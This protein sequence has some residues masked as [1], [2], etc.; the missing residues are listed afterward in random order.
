MPRSLPASAS[1][2]KSAKPM[3]AGTMISKE[4]SPVNDTR[5]TRAG[6]P[7]TVPSRQDMKGKASRERSMSWQTRERSSRLLGPAITA[8]DR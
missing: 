6:M 5:S 8:V 3:L 4:S 1:A 2:R 7:A